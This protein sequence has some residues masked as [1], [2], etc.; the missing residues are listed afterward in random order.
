MPSA[1]ETAYPRLKSHLSPRELAMVY[2]P[3]KD[4]VT[5]AEGVTRSDTARVGFLVLLKTFQRLGY[6]VQLRDVP[7]TIMEH[8][9]QTQGFLVVPDALADYDASGTRRRHVPLIRAYQHVNPFGVEG[10]VGPPG[11]SAGKFTV[12][13]P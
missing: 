5:L 11:A 4:E 8:I 2:T 12:S 10:Q 13:T 6:F 1:Y 7:P 9:A 3:T